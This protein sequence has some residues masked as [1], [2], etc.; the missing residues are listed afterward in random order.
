MSMAG[1]KVAKKKRG[2]ENLSIIRRKQK[3]AVIVLRRVNGGSLTLH[4]YGGVH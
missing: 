3:G 1:K 2:R 4:V